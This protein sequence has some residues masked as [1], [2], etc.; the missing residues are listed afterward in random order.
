MEGSFIALHMMSSHVRKAPLVTNPV[1]LFLFYVEDTSD[2]EAVEG[3]G[4][5]AH[6]MLQIISESHMDGTYGHR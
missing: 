3:D 2:R 5:L 1:D 6:F 4:D